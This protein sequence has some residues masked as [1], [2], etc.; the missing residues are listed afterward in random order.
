MGKIV[1]QLP[2]LV[3]NK[4]GNGKVNMKQIER[5]T[6]LTYATVS[7]WLKDQINRVDFPTLAI[8]CKY[9]DVQPGDILKYEADK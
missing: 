8:W 5:D 9:L 7:A 4:F 6:G 3:A 2:I 1:N